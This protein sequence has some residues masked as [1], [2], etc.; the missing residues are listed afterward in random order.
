MKRLIASFTALGLIA[1][2]AMAATTPATPSKAQVK[3]AK[4]SKKSAKL[5]KAAAPK[6]ASK[7]N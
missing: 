2:P 1:A 7:A 5:V 3:P 6:P 4:A